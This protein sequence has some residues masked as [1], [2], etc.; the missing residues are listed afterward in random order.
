MSESSAYP[1]PIAAP[2]QH[3]AEKPTICL[4]MIVKNERHVIERLIAQVAPYLSYW[5]IVDTGSSDGTQGLIRDRF[6]E[7]G[8]AG[9][10]HERPWRDFGHNRSEAL[11]LADG[12]ADYLWVIDADDS[13]DGTLDLSDLTADGYALRIRSGFDYWRQQLF[14]SG[15]GWRYEGV[16][17]EYPE[18][19]QPHTV[20]RIEGDYAILS[21]R[22]GA[23]S[24]DPLKY[25]K[26]ALV[27]EAALRD[28]PGNARYWYY[29]GQSWMDAGEPARA[30]EAFRRRVALGGWD[31]EAYCAQLR[32]GRCLI[33]TEAPAAE[34]A[35][36][37]LHA[38]EI[39]PIRAEA[40][41]ELARYL[42]LHDRFEAATLFALE[43]VAIA[44]PLD[45]IL[46]VEPDVYR[47]QAL[48][49]LAVSAYYSAR[50]VVDGY[51]ACLRVL[52]ITGLSDEVRARTEENRSYYETHHGL[53]PMALDERGG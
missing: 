13:I 53:G 47:Y 28:D 45:D 32:L 2:A 30:I 43:A 33:R 38:Y 4:A 24:Q 25:H 42:R 36:A 44:P 5:V 39:R 50:H 21:G 17:H 26:D 3:A 10:L 8:I 51:A 20:V 12:H 48:D 37:L 49:E 19:D 40:L 18:C 15:M 6:A 34:V 41:W 31:E 46:F 1:E 9:E 11:A 29:L 7:L 14:R 27:L 23:R 35:A 16:L 52:A 22:I